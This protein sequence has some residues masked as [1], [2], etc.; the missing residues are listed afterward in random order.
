MEVRLVFSTHKGAAPRVSPPANRG[1]LPSDF[2]TESSLQRGQ[3]SS[4]IHFSLTAERLGEL[5]K[6]V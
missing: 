6:I 2:V 3:W 5:E 4:V 1:E